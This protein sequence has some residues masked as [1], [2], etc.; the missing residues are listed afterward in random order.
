MD[1]MEEKNKCYKIN[2]F[3]RC[4]FLALMTITKWSLVNANKDLLKTS[5]TMYQSSFYYY[6]N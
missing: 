5:S 1:I 4:H 6:K 2:L 3:E